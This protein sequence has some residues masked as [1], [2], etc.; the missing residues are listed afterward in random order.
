ML[1]EVSQAVLAPDVDGERCIT[2]LAPL[3]R[4]QGSDIAFL[5]NNKY[6]GALESS[7][8]G[9]CIL[10]AKHADR[11][12]PGVG[13]LLS[14]QP[15][16]AFARIAR[17]FYPQARLEPGIS[18]AAHVD[19]RARIA[20]GCRIDPGAAI[21]EGE[22]PDSAF[23]GDEDGVIRVVIGAAPGEKCARCWKVLEEVD[24]DAEFRHVCLR[25]ADAVRR[26]SM[27]AQ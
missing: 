6:I 17:A 23:S 27:A 24:S 2:D 19:D 8:A 18:S 20:T 12:P 9:A 11:A 3:D 16:L 1:A 14:E 21:A 10:A 25:C 15:Y 5:D 4:A 7:G 22:A 13:L 26:H